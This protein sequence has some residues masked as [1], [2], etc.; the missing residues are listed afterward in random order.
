MKKQTGVKSFLTILCFLLVI[1]LP[2]QA[3]DNE[4]YACKNNKT[5]K[6][7]FVS[8]PDK[9]KTK[10]EH[11][12]IL[13][14][15]AQQAPDNADPIVG[16]WTFM[17]IT[18]NH[19]N[20]EGYP[21]A[22]GLAVGDLEINPDG[23]YVGWNVLKTKDSP[24]RIVQDYSGTW[25]KTSTYHYMAGKTASDYDVILSKDGIVG[26]WTSSRTTGVGTVGHYEYG[27]MFKVTV[28][29]DELK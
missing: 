23:T 14:G 5:G 24:D 18:V 9:C 13:N 6:P 2:C 19:P 29:R 10:T 7:R 1:W 26:M 20:S 25:V 11:L 3:A 28:N 17:Q 22:P 4:I 16:H 27:Q 8:S 21:N 12:V 15:T